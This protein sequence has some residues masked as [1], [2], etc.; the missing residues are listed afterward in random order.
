M[1]EQKVTPETVPETVPEAPLFSFGVDL[2]EKEYLKFRT[3]AKQTPNM[4]RNQRMISAGSTCLVT[5]MCGF[6]LWQDSRQGIVDP[7]TV[8]LLV[9]TLLTGV[10][11]LAVMPFWLTY[12]T[13]KEYRHIR[14]W[15][16]SYLGRVDVY[17][18]RLEKR[19][20]K[21]RV[22]LPFNYLTKY[23][24]RE[25]V[26]MFASMGQQAVVIPARY[27]TAEHLGQLRR[28]VKETLPPENLQL[29]SALIPGTAVAMP[30]PEFADEVG[31]PQIFMEFTV[32]Y[33]A[34]ETLFAKRCEAQQQFHRR[35]P[36]IAVMALMIGL[37]IA[38]TTGDWWAG[39]LAVLLLT[40]FSYVMG[41]TVPNSRVRAL[42]QMRPEDTPVMKLTLTDQFLMIQTR[43]VPSMRL[44]WYMIRRAVNTPDYIRLYSG[45]YDIIIP[46][47]CLPD[48]AQ[49]C[50]LVDRYMLRGE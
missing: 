48:E 50:A 21:N 9:L 11:S 46:K 27:L 8:L 14:E 47:R 22:V 20:E 15:G 37:L 30:A 5:L 2:T 13:K 34:D 7:Y 45:V 17:A 25:D 12:K 40:G 31:D 26:L 4:L 44:P 1:E 24:E 32:A 43:T 16:Y 28:L 39:L 3:T 18:D 49:F 35:I 10:F 36:S 6:M 42:L 38:L 29:L 23:I 41:V 33:N 19:T